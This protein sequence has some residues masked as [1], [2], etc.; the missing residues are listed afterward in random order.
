M[1]RINR[2]DF[3]DSPLDNREKEKECAFCG[4][5]IYEDEMFCSKDCAKAYEND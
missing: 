3:Y 5:S 1:T 4:C 2:N